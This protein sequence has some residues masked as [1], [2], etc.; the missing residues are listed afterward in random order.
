MTQG[1]V[2]AGRK[3]NVQFTSFAYGGID[4]NNDFK[5][6]NEWVQV[7]IAEKFQSSSSYNPVHK[8]CFFLKTRKQI[9]HFR[10]SMKILLC[11]LIS[12]K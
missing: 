4:L 5:I 11:R 10:F 9:I 12:R 2:D 7:K 8:K 3:F 6:I 1:P